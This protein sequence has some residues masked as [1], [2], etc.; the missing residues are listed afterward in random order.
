MDEEYHHDFY[1]KCLDGDCYHPGYF[2]NIVKPKVT[3]ASCTARLGFQPA[4]GQLQ[5][6]RFLCNVF[7]VKRL[8]QGASS[9]R[10]QVDKARAKGHIPAAADDEL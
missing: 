10:A 9:A 2:R 8:L 7:S 1:N 4:I 5:D 3:R 6:L